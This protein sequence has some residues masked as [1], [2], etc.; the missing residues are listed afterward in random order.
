MQFTF[1]KNILQY[2]F[3]VG[4]SVSQNRALSTVLRKCWID[5]LTILSI[6]KINL[7][8]IRITKVSIT[9]INLT[10]MQIWHILM[11]RFGMS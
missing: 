3:F 11:F 7:T 1:A 6:T 10:C 2:L 5:G 9:R 8:I 4:L